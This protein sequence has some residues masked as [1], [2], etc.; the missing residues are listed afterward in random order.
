MPGKTIALSTLLLYVVAAISGGFGGCV[1]ANY[2]AI[3]QAHAKCILFGAHIVFGVFFGVMALAA[4][5]VLH[6]G[7]T[8]IDEVI[9]K[10]LIAGVIG[11]TV[12]AS[13]NF[14]A[15]VILRKMGWE[16]EVNFV[17]KADD[18]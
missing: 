12:L 3:R 15:R 1:V 11:S 2:A 8:T 14:G 5:E 16:I 9:F 18:D 7:F 4:G 13:T 10:C 6:T 17:R